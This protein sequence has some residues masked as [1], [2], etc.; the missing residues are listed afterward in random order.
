M[1]NRLEISSGT[2]GLVCAISLSASHG[3]NLPLFL[4][5]ANLC[6]C[7]SVFKTFRNT[8]SEG[9]TVTL[10]CSQKRKT[11]T[12]DTNGVVFKPQYVIPAECLVSELLWWFGP[13]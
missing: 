7:A 9:D 1:V 6:V 10:V 13:M 12:P 2:V 11:N 4:C 3:W 5:Y 8:A